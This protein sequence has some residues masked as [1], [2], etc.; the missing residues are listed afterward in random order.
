MGIE[1]QGR[2]APE[3]SRCRHQESFEMM[4]MDH[5]HP[6]PPEDLPEL[7]RE[8]G[9]EQSQLHVGGARGQ[10]LIRLDF[11]DA[12]NGQRGARL[13]TSVMVRDHMDLVSTRSHPF[14]QSLNPDW[15]TPAGRV[16]AGRDHCDVRADP[17][18]QYWAMY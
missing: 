10:V 2:S 8:Q 12:M 13:G 4:S 17:L 1:D 16:R 9:V 3:P 15:R 18:R 7:D 6:V 11:R 5:V 14:G